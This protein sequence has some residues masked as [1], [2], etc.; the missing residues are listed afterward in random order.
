MSLNGYN[1]KNE[2]IEGIGLRRLE[3]RFKKEIG[4][5]PKLF[6]RT[7]RVNNAI[8]QMKVKTGKS[9]TQLALENNYFDQ[10]HFINDFKQFTG[11]SP[12]KFLKSITPNGDI[13]NLRID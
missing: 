13:L 2:N 7:I 12:S 8:E 1:I 11:Y 4:I 10:S 9:L 5:S 6:S 3:Q